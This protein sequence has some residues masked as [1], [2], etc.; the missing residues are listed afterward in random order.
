MP[1]KTDGK[2]LDIAAAKRA[3]LKALF[4]GVFTE[5]TKEDGA[6]SESVDFEKLK[7]ELGAFSDVFETRRERYGME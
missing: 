3:E 7:A 5:T 6:I 1:E 2:S 4:P